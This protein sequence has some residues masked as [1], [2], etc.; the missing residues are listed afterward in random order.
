MMHVGG[1]E[2]AKARM[3]VLGVVPEKEDVAVSSR[4]LDRAEALWERRP[5]LQRLELRL[6]ERVS[7]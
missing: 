1:R 6:R 7:P 5:I 2:Q 4:I 3:M